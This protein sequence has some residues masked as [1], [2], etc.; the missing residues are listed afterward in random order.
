MSRFDEF[1]RTS[2]FTDS[3][4]A[5][6]VHVSLKNLPNTDMMS[7]TDSFCVIHSYNAFDDTWEQMGKTSVCYDNLSPSYPEAFEL[8]Y[9]FEEKQTMRVEV[10]DEDVQGSDNLSDHKKLGEI[11]FE[12]GTLMAEDGQRMGLTPFG[13]HDDCVIILQG[14]ELGF[15]SDF[16]QFQLEGIGLVNK[17]M[18][19]FFGDMLKK[20]DPFFIM[21]R[22]LENG[23]EV[24]VLRSSIIEDN[25]DPVWPIYDISIRNTCAGNYDIP[26]IIE[27]WHHK[28][29]GNHKPMGR[30]EVTAGELKEEGTTFQVELEGGE[31]KGELK[32]KFSLLYKRPTFIDYLKGGMDLN[33]MIGIDYTASNRLAHDPKS[34]HYLDPSG[35]LNPYQL[36]MKSILEIVTMYDTDKKIPVYGFGA[37]SNLH[38]EEETSMCFPVTGEDFNSNASAEVDGSDGVF[39]AYTES[40]TQDK[41]KFAGPTL[42]VPILRKAIEK[43]QQAKETFANGGP[44]EYTVLLMMTDGE[45]TDFSRTKS[46][47]SEAIDVPLSII[48]VGVGNEDFSKMDEL[49]GDGAQ[50][51]GRDIVQFVPYNKYADGGFY[52]R[53]AKDVLGEVPG[54]LLEYTK[55][56]NL[57]P[58]E[59]KEGRDF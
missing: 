33:T 10:Y 5:I 6:Q 7:K 28:S 13:G 17:S 46:L 24:E 9:F 31:K 56:H 47:L 19:N 49:D 23:S 48:I 34:L 36:A 38:P 30:V 14:E 4:S 40:L 58:G 25:D 20:S 8:V 41:F 35:R 42:F 22:P 18:W 54:Q 11:T 57:L 27:L 37:K 50:K 53:L 59:P 15:C 51:L 1:G 44:L 3:S 12:L 32:V 39:D 45:I 52:G 26:L 16:L 43:A 29:S 21:K 55:M 2:A